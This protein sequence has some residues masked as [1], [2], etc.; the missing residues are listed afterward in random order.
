MLSSALL[1]I[2]QNLYSQYKSLKDSV[3]ANY[4]SNSPK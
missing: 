3:V 2:F 4:N 1:G